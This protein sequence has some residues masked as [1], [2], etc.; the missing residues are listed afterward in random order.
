M[1]HD[2]TFYWFKPNGKYYSEGTGVFPQDPHK[3]TRWLFTQEEIA[4]A[5][6]G[7][8]PG[9]RSKRTPLT[10]V[11]I[12]FEDSMKKNAWPRIVRPKIYHNTPESSI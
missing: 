12:P 9:L 8:L 6:G 7:V 11:V 10:C 3:K 5:N 2:A 4:K 1:Q